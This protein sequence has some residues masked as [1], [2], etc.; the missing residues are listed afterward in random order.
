M[1]ARLWQR[2]AG[3]DTAELQP[4]EELGRGSRLLPGVTESDSADTD[5][6]SATMDQAMPKSKDD[7]N[8]I[9]QALW[10]RNALY[11]E[12][13]GTPSEQKLGPPADAARIAAVEQKF[14]FALPDDYR[15]FLA[16]HDG[17]SGFWEDLDLLSTT[18]I[19]GGPTEQ[20][21]QWLKKEWR[22]GGEASFSRGAVF[23][24]AQSKTACAFYDSPAKAAPG[25]KPG[26]IVFW[27]DGEMLSRHRD[28]KTYLRD[29]LSLVEAAISEVR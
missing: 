22:A 9:V 3:A 10:D 28:F 19:L 29:T 21:I 6:R 7:L 15:A 25:S 1:D 12:L 4:V 18:Q 23:M 24:G 13:T 16:T 2:L 26:S 27:D 17:W 20:W 5:S 14:G 8:Q 11:A